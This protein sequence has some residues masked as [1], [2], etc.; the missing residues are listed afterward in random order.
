MPP[1]VETRSGVGCFVTFEGGEGSGKTTQIA[2]L[3]ARLRGRGFDVVETRE[4]GG[5]PGADALR[6]II[7]SGAAESLG[8]EMEAILFAAA[9][10]D[11][12]TSL[13]LPALDRDAIVLCD[14]FHDSTRAYQG[15]SDGADAEFLQSLEDATLEM[16][17]P[18]LTLLLDVPA[19]IGLHRAAV[20][21]SGRAVDRFEKEDLA[22][23]ERRR[24]AFLE[25]A[26]QEP[27]RCVVI[28]A[29]GNAEAIEAAVEA[30]FRSR[31][32]R[33]ADAGGAVE[34][35]REA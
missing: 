12:L 10:L 23:H 8:N 18:D 11:H 3:A 17:G 29:T 20:R 7:L 13:I 26:H 30:A 27:D 32:P 4:P 1:T 5:T 31:L 22:I 19:E 15:S 9:R 35:R 16:R 33:W 6:Q 21:R 2:R 24:Q 28:D 14:R 34:R 25:I